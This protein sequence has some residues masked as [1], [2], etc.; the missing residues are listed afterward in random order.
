MKKTFFV[1]LAI[2][3]STNLYAQPNIEWETNLGGSYFDWARS[4]QQTT[5]GQYIVVGQSTSNDGDVG[6]NNGNSDYWIVKLDPS[7]TLVWEN[8][9]GGSNNDFDPSLQQTTDGG[10]IIAG[11]SSSIDGDVGGNNGDYDFWIVKLDSSGDLV[12]ETNLGGSNNDMAYSIQQSTNGGY[13]VAGQSWSNDGDVGG[14]NGS[15]DIWIVKLDASGTLVWENNL[16][17]SN[18]D[19]AQSIQQ[20]TDDGY[21]VAGLSYS[22]DGDVGGNNGYEDYWILK[23][24]TNGGLV[25]ETNLGGSYD[26]GAQ[27]IQQTTDGGYIVAGRSDSN[28]GDLGGNNGSYDYWIVKL[29]PSGTLVWETN[30]GGSYEDLASSIQQTSDGGYI[31]VGASKSNDGDVGGNNGDYDFW[32]VKLDSSGGL[33]WESNLG[34]SNEDLASSIQ[35][36]LDGGYIV[37]GRSYSNNG[38]VGGNNGGG[39]YWIVKLDAELSVGDYTINNNITLY[40]NPTANTFTI[41]NLSE[42]ISKVEILDLQG[43][44]ILVTSEIHNSIVDISN[45]QP[46]MYI[47]KIY[48]STNVYT[49]QIIK[50]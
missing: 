45:L 1:T 15:S 47:V 37:A 26:D 22:N 16:G 43:R 6:G 41:A 3:I 11:V 14:N 49:Q 50:K 13:I 20:T 31:V 44:I 46:A 21:I 27:S 2:I 12:W 18:Y 17:G 25:W 42:E 9:L 34:G 38:D 35:H 24:D 10:Y 40:P 39:D 5:D 23:L 30:L 36:T 32:I 48:A 8:N 19:E 28:D 29:D 4:I 33:V 7:G